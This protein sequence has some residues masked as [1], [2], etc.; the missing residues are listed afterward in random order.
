MFKILTKI[1]NISDFYFT[2]KKIFENQEIIKK[3]FIKFIVEL[4]F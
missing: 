3:I 1:Q 4:L 2:L